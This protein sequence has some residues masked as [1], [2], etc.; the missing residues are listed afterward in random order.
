METPSRNA[1]QNWAGTEEGKREKK[2]ATWTSPGLCWISEVF[3][4]DFTWTEP[5]LG[6][7]STWTLSWAGRN[8]SE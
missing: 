3:H 1:A 4:L 6:P 7:D 5:G 2:R 8:P